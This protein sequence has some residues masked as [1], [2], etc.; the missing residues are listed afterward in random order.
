MLPSPCAR[1]LDPE[2]RVR[3]LAT[4]RLESPRVISSNRASERG[5]RRRRLAA[6]QA[7]RLSNAETG[8]RAAPRVVVRREN[9]N[10]A[11]A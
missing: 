10:D 2:A 1:L 3:S 9:D 8:A 5:R 6:M 7:R 11:G 4:E